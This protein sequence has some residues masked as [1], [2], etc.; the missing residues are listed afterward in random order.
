MFDMV[1]E[2]YESSGMNALKLL[3]TRSI[4]GVDEPNITDQKVNPKGKNLI[5]N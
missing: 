5:T 4:P 1:C 2:K 3:K